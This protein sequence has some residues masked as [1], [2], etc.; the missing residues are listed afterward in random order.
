MKDF[1]ISFG[2][3]FLFVGSVFLG[4]AVCLGFKGEKALELSV[5]SG[6]FLVL[7][8]ICVLYLC[9]GDEVDLLEPWMRGEEDSEESSEKIIAFTKRSAGV[10][11][12]LSMLGSRICLWLLIYCFLIVR[13]E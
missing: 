9:F 4:G 10:A 13:L 1:A 12:L 2:A 8:L 7:F 3:F 11:G 6:V 5:I